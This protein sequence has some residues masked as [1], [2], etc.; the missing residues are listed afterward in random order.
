MSRQ[1]DG[2]VKELEEK[3]KSILSEGN[4]HTLLMGTEDLERG[5][6]LGKLETIDSILKGIYEEKPKAKA[7]SK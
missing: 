5:R 7:I 3:K 2:L 4:F 1:I 6:I